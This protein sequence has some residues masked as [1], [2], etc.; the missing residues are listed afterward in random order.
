MHQMYPLHESMDGNRRQSAAVDGLGAKQ[1]CRSAEVCRPSDSRFVGARALLWMDLDGCFTRTKVVPPQVPTPAVAA[2]DVGRVPPSGIPWR[3][4]CKQIA[5]A[6]GAPSAA[7]AARPARVC[8][9]TRGRGLSL[10]RAL[11][12]TVKLW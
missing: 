7:R 3:G 1:P 4:T 10:G 2:D 11:A 9:I 8:G 12:G 6:G 5:S